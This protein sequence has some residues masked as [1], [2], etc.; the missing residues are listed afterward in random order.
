ML[1][2]PGR[3]NKGPLVVAMVNLA[4]MLGALSQGPDSPSL[5][6]RLLWMALLIAL[7]AELGAGVLLLALRRQPRLARALLFGALFFIAL[8][9]LVVGATCLLSFVP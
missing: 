2:E 7:A 3:F 4:L 9:V 1:E 6:G 8:V 5:A